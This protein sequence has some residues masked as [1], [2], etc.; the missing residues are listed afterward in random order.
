MN[1]Y[2]G[3]NVINRQHLKIV[4]FKS[5]LVEN[6][7]KQKTVFT[8]KAKTHKSSYFCQNSINEFFFEKNNKKG[9]NINN[10]NALKIILTQTGSS[11]DI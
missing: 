1:R 6:K 4:S 5:S 10:V 2:H 8:E 9:N 3:I 11:K 7:K